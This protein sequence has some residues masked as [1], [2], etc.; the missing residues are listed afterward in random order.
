M[1]PPQRPF[2]L[3]YRRSLDG[4]RGAAILLVVLHHGDTIGE[5]FGF[6]GVNTFFVLSGF[7]ITCLLVAE[8]DASHDISL[9]DFY[10]RRALRLLPALTI[11]LLAFLVFA[12]LTDPRGRAF[13]ELNEAL[14]A[15]FYSTNWA[16]VFRIGRHMSLSHTWSLSVEEQFYIV[17]P[18]LLFFVLPRTSRT[19]LLCWI[20]LAAFLSVII[21]IILFVGG[22]TNLAGNILPMDLH[23]LSYGTDTRA[24]S[25]LLGCFGGVLVSSNLLPRKAWFARALKASA[26]ASGLVLLAMGACPIWS[27]WM[28][29]A[30]WFLASV[31]AMILIMHLAS[32]THSLP[33]RF[34][35]FP[36]LVYIGQISYGLYIWHAPIRVALLQYHV[37]S[38]NV[39][40]LVFVFPVVLMSY[41]LIERPCLRLKTR[42]QRAG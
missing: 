2:R 23:R 41:Y 25:L 13:R 26:L 32:A 3:G 40:Y 27:A 20:F 16:F 34:L 4:V 14:F 18:V 36:A 17:W 37:P 10:V 7:L 1:I 5:G 24:D 30:G 12:F 39:M 38:E 6:I 35:E 28:I 8:W 9:R 33:R 22:T 29:C 11:M 31:L 19:S 42:F 21:R 15:L